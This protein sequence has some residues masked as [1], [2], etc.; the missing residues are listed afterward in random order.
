MLLLWQDGYLWQPRCECETYT[1]EM[2]RS[3]V[4]S[5]SGLKLNEEW[6]LYQRISFSKAN[7][8]VDHPLNISSLSF[9]LIHRLYFPSLTHSKFAE[10]HAAQMWYKSLRAVSNLFIRFL[11]LGNHKVGSY[12]KVLPR[13]FTTLLCLPLQTL[14]LLTET[15]RDFSMCRY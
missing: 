3:D 15:K 13:L 1:F 6:N 10:K 12:L 5:Y 7:S 14:S 9:D 8:F 11:I 2:C 4:L